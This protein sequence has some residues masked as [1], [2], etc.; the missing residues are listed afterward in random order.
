MYVAI[1]RLHPLTR[2]GSECKTM[3]KL[4]YPTSFL[5]FQGCVQSYGFCGESGIVEFLEEWIG[6]RWK[7][8]FLFDLYFFVSFDFKNFCNYNVGI[9]LYSWSP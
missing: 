7:C 8:D 1:V 6:I 9:I 3:F 5:G 4:N 2:E